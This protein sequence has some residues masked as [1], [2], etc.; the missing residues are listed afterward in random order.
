MREQGDGQPMAR[1]SGGEG[2]DQ[3]C[4]GEACLNEGIANDIIIVVG[5]DEIEADYLSIDK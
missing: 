2:L 1:R 5:C 4:P 3:A